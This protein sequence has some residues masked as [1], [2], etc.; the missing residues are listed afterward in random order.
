MF[1]GF[2]ELTGRGVLLGSVVLSDKSDEETGPETEDNADVALPLGCVVWVASECDSDTFFG[3]HVDSGDNH[4]GHKD[5]GYPQLNLE[6]IVDVLHL[7][8][9]QELAD[10][11]GANTNSSDN[12]REV[13]GLRSGN[14]G[15]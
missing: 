2:G 8:V 13:D 3:E 15:L 5:S 6:L 10:E 9:S 1:A 4:D 7:D 12:E 11:G 14:H